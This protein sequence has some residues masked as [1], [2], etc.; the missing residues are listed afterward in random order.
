MRFPSLSLAVCGLSL[1]LAGCGQPPEPKFALN[2]KTAALTPPAQ[3][4]ITE[5]LV[6][7]FGTPNNL[8]AWQELPIDYGKGNPAAD[9]EHRQHDGWRLK[10]GRDLYM[11]HCL[12]CHGVAG[13]GNGST[14][15]FLNPRPRD[16]RQGKFKF[17]STAGGTRPT[18]DDLMRILEEGIPGTYMPSFVLLGKD[19]L[20]L[21]VDYVRWLSMRGEVEE[22]LAI[23]L[24]QV[25]LKSSDLERTWREKKAEDKAITLDAVRDELLAQVK[26]AW[27]ETVAEKAKDVV[28]F[29]N[30]ANNPENLVVPQEKR[31]ASD[32]ES[33]ARGRALYLSKE[34]KCSDCHGPAGR[35]DGP[36]TEQFAAIDGASPAR[37]YDEPGLRDA[38][39]NVI[40][41]RN[42]TRGVYRF[43]RRPLDLYRRVHQGIN[44]TPMPGFGKTLKDEQIWD[45]VNYVL[46]IPYQ[47]GTAPAAEDVA[48]GEALPETASR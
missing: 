1:A 30:E 27:T 10:D 44:G 4:L 48:G 2:A 32:A 36:Q 5:A 9:A 31:T 25:G 19:Q 45:I 11:V 20:G 47:E 18:H 24:A 40:M 8:V 17:K 6:E 14:A 42:L 12:H 35:G 21:I 28:D 38:W 29:W 37:N 3:Q 41:P 7:N 23:E 26:S 43:G 34:N 33:I 13:D 15:R 46:S 22:A 39:G 16:Y